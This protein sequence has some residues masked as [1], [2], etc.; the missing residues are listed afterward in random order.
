[1]KV[2]Y[3]IAVLAVCALLP[4]TVAADVLVDGKIQLDVT[5]NWEGTW[6]NLSP[7]DVATNNP[8]GFIEFATE[9]GLQNTTAAGALWLFGGNDPTPGASEGAQILL[10]GGE[11]A[12]TGTVEITT[13]S[14][15]GD[16][17]LTSVSNITMVAAKGA[18]VTGDL[19][20]SGDGTISGDTLTLT[21]ANVILTDGYGIGSTINNRWGLAANGWPLANSSGDMIFNIDAD[22]SG[23]T[24]A[25]QIWKDRTD[26]TGGT[27]LMRVQ[28]DGNVGIGTNAPSTNAEINGGANQEPVFRLTRDES[29]TI[30]NANAIIGK[31]DF[32]GLSA[33]NGGIGAQIVGIS[34]SN[35]G[36]NDYPCGVLI[37]TTPNGSGTLTDRWKAEDDGTILHH[38]FLGGA[39]GIITWNDGTNKYET[40]VGG[41]VT[42]IT[43]F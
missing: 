28:E 15:H 39:S 8:S 22:D 31:F 13:G 34:G 17:I 4:F 23:T 38:N 9:T 27:E 16:I 12:T 20:V 35:W 40:I 36:N 24:G 3:L 42:N 5:G 6:Q 32:Y 14:Q 41:A 29:A 25:F 10:Q 18:F 21:T 30:I 43:S 1:M 11:T 7:S 2:L 19:S 26:R 37:R 33:G